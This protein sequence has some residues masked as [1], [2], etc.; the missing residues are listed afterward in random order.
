METQDILNKKVGTKETETLKPE[1]VKLVGIKVVEVGDKKNQK[2]EVS[3]KHSG[4]EELINISSVTY[5]DKN[6][7]KS[8]GLWYNEDEDGNIRKGSAL[9]IFLQ[10]AGVESLADLAGKDYMTTLDAKG[11]LT[12]KAF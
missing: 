4:R 5:L 8:S 9:A 6:S 2:V 10:N 12:F 1:K 11:Y 3:V 7:V